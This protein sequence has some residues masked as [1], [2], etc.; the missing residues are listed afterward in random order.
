MLGGKENSKEE[1]VAQW[2]SHR[3]LKVE[4][5]QISCLTVVTAARPGGAL[6]AC[7]RLLQRTAA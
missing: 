4:V 6:F 2:G 3:L 5:P 7:E 1:P